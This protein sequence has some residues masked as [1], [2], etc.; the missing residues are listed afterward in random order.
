[1][2]SLDDIERRLRLP[3]PDEPD[4]LPTLVL[5]GGTLGS[6]LVRGPIRAGSSGIT[7]AIG[8]RRL[9][10]AV[11]LLLGALAAAVATGALRLDPWQIRFDG[12][13]QF[14]ADGISIEIPAG[15]VQLTPSDPT[16][17]STGMTSLVAANMAV[18]G[19]TEADIPRITPQPAVP[20]GEEQEAFSPSYAG[21]EDQIFECTLHEPMQPGEIRVALSRGVPQK[22]GVGPIEPFDGT[23]WYGAD[24]SLGTGLAYMPSPEDGWTHS[25]DAMPAK[26]V[27]V[28]S[29]DDGG[30]DEVRTWAVFDPRTPGTGPWF[31]RF[32]LRGPDLDAL[33]VQADA[34][35][36]SLRFTRKPPALDERQRD[37]K[38]AEAIDRTD[39]DFR[40]FRGSR[41]YGCFLRTPGEREVLLED[42]P[43]GPLP[44]PL[45]VTCTTSI[46]TTPLRLWRATLRL[47]WDAGV[48]YPA[49][50]WDTEMLF[51]M[52]PSIGAGGGSDAN[53]LVRFPGTQGPVEPAPPGPLALAVG[54]IVQV[55]APGIDQDQ[56]G[57]IQALY[58]TPSETIGGRIVYDAQAGRRFAIVGGPLR[59]AGSDWYLVESSFGTAYPGEIVWLSAVHDDVPLVKVVEPACPVKPG[60]TD[61][62]Y[63]L[64][65]ERVLCYGAEPLTLEPVTVRRA[66]PTTVGGITG[67]PGWLASDPSL[68]LYGEGGPEGV[69][70]PLAVAVA[71]SLGDDLPIGPWLRVTGHFDDPS[72]GTCERVFPEGWGTPEPPDIQHRRCSQ[73]FVVT[74]VEERGAP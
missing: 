3:A 73:V 6:G 4:L 21:I 7:F 12:Y 48:G 20:S 52:D 65:A 37:A 34:L 41:M 2:H 11:L 57:P 33:R 9:A 32:A 63:M 66:D 70:G 64:P 58:A 59:H 19:C 39:R 56:G 49:G 45:R 43:A 14:A 35:A 17:M 53:D 30:P 5:P 72:A 28:A 15:W 55:V 40:E 46:E 60:L 1:M 69:E 38:L 61:L 29:S 18:E 47:T 74:G 25:I 68:R 31:V 27:A 42:G 50:N 54:D 51:G 24:G 22:V 71:P 36:A 16:S 67:A 8:S 23:A 26:M 13:R 44:E 10:L 62:L